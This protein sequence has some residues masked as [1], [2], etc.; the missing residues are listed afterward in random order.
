M[1]YT[2]VL[3]QHQNAHLRRITWGCQMPMTKTMGS[4]FEY[5]GTVLDK[6]KICNA[7]KDKAFCENCDFYLEGVSNA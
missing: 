6:G 1:A 2:P 5:L 4:I 7:C 3:N